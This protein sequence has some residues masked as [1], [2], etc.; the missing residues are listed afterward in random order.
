MKCPR[1]QFDNP[2]GIKFCGECGAKIEK[3]CPKCNSSNPPE[4]KFCGECGHDFRKP[5]EAPTIDYAEPQSYTPKLL[6]ENI[7]DSKTLA[8]RFG[9]AKGRVDLD[10]L[11]L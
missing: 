2:E 8:M 3:I 5:K 7:K 6:A 4:F 9:L 1:C 10:K 11:F